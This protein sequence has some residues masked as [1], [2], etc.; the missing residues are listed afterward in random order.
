MD[1]AYETARRTLTEH[2]VELHKVAGV[3][4]EREKISGEE[5]K[6]LME[7]G[8]LP[9]YDIASGETAKPEAPAPENAEPVQPAEQPA[10][11][12]PAEPDNAQPDTQE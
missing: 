12:Q 6:T 11:P 3:L 7:G 2:M 9:P 5:F 4:M 1:E 10:T 8:T